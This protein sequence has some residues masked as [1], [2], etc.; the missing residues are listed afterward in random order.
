MSLTDL[1]IKR[2]KAPERGQKTYYDPGLPGFGVRVSQGGAKTFVVVYGKGR[3]RQSLGRYPDVSLS[4]ARILAKRAQADIALDDLTPSQD[5]PE[6]S[7]ETAR[8]KFLADTEARTKTR[9]IDEY[10]RLLHR[11]FHFSGSLQELTRDQIARPIETLRATP[12]EQQHAFVAIRTMMNW[13]VRRGYLHV[14]PAPAL[15]F[16]SKPRE[17]VLNDIELAAVWHRA[18][19][20]G[21]PYGPIVQLLILTG[22]RRGEI[23]GLR[24]SW[25][26]DQMIRYPSEFVKNQRPHSIP[27]GDWAM[28]I[29]E[30]LPEGIDLLFP[31]RL[32]DEKPFIGFSKAKVA[33]DRE[34]AIA[35]YTLHDLRRTFSSTMAKL[36]TPIHVTEKMLNHVSGTISG[37]AAVYNRHAYIEEMKEAYASHEAHI[38]SLI[39]MHRPES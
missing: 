11:H 20:Y 15:T 25:I 23:V 34:L 1:Q 35:P 27:L 39:E 31:S 9:T 38:R 6:V 28:S 2:L 14:S 32:D 37:V 22:Q 12:S 36:G 8:D 7:F 4:E 10:R 19:G 33:F 18:E 3:R 26:E 24:S 29:I 30:D 21:W 17:R 5:L 16:K 13:C